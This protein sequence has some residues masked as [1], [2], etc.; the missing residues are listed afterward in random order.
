MLLPINSIFLA[1]LV[2][3]SNKL[4]YREGE[5]LVKKASDS[6]LGQF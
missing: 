4:F 1:V 2:W 6:R 5:T 3:A